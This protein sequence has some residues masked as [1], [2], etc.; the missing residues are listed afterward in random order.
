VYA[1]IA[2]LGEWLPERVRTNAEWPTNFAQLAAV[3]SD[4]ELLD[5]QSIVTCR[6]D[7]IALRCLQA[8][9][10][11]PF[12]GS[13][14]RRVADDALTSAQAEANAAQVA[15]LDAGLAPEQIDL[16]I[17]W[18]AV[19]DRIC[20]PTGSKVAELVGADRAYAVGI[21]MACGS[22]VAQIEFAAALIESGRARHVLLTQSHLLSRAFKLVHPASPTV[23]DAATAIVMGPSATP[24]V[25]RT[26]GLSQGRYHE[27]VTW[28]RGTKKDPPW[29]EAG[30]AFYV[31]SRNFEQAEE[32]VRSTVRLAAETI[33]DLA[34][35]NAIS[36]ADIDLLVSVQPRKWVSS[37]IVEALGL[38]IPCPQTFE[39]LGHLGGCGIVTN[40]L[41]A[42]RQGLLQQERR[43]ALYGQGAGFTRAATLIS[44]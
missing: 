17:S 12:L 27:A 31:G 21:D 4:R 11:D 6:A 29:Y 1:R 23:G 19:P 5:V 34:R 35:A 3:S 37:A 24:S 39:T 32:L 30:G 2:G 10:A 44:W 16:V 14:E 26:V 41:A 15:I 18:T 7:E 40:L 13:R 43:I 36:L 22:T 9:A 28:C 33:T 8:E 42:R 25:L 38:S 20:P